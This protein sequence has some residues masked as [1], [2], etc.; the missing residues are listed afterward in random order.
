MNTWLL[1]IAGLLGAG[2]VAGALVQ[3]IAARRDAERFPA[4]GRMVDVGGYRLHMHVMG[5]GGPTVVL[6]AGLDLFSTNWFW[7]QT[8]LA[9]STRVVSYDRAGLGWSDDGSPPRRRIPQRG[10]TAHGTPDRRH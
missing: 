9:S 7:V 3:T 1:G 10:G 4:P 2:A 8:A 5:S 6:E